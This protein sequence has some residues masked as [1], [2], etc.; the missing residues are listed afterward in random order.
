[1]A[2]H[3]ATI[4]WETDG[5][6]FR[7]RQYS[8]KHTWSFDGGLTVPGSSSPS[9][10]RVPYSD[11]AA[12]DPE[13]AFVAALASCH[14]MTFLHVASQAGFVVTRY[15]DEAVGHMTKNEHGVPWVST[16]VLSPRITYAG[17][18]PSDDE[19]DALHHRAHEECFISQSVKTAVTT[20]P[21]RERRG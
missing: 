9:V 1:M 13:E 12:V 6:D 4:R 18:P 8:R 2:D 10:V 21:A 20:L 14:M 11:P 3:R 19:E 16:T 7:R 15:E 17:T 5:G